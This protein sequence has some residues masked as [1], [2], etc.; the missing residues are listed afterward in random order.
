[1][2]HLAPVKLGVIKMMHAR[3]YKI[4]DDDLQLYEDK[5]NISDIMQ[6]CSRS[7]KD[8][9][10]ENRKNGRW[11]LSKIYTHEEDE[12]TCL[13][14]FTTSAKKNFLLDDVR[15]VNLMIQYTN[16]DKCVVISEAPTGIQLNKIPHEISRPLQFF[17][18]DEMVYDPTDHIFSS[19]I[20]LLTKRDITS[21]GINPSELPVIWSTDP[22]VKRMWYERGS[23]VRLSSPVMIAGTLLNTTISYRLVKDPPS[24]PK[25]ITE[26]SST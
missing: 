6:L 17:E 16:V 19:S 2:E 14:V 11:F 12:H 23:V 8:F 24:K 20:S 5:I 1:M 10:S 26:S 7:I 25:R 3:G 9:V 13:V 21:A 4:D 15:T 22:L 18:D